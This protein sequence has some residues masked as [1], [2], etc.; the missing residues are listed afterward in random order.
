[1]FAKGRDFLNWLQFR[2]FGYL[3]LSKWNSKGKHETGKMLC[4]FQKSKPKKSCVPP[5]RKKSI[6]TLMKDCIDC[7]FKTNYTRMGY[8]EPYQKQSITLYTSQQPISSMLIH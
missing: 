3:F 1:M 8:N 2:Q 5:K 6:I 7:Q 4:S